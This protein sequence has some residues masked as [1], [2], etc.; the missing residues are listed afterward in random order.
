M[1][2]AWFFSGL[3]NSDEISVTSVTQPPKD[4]RKLRRRTRNR[5]HHSASVCI[6]T[7]SVV[8]PQR[9]VKSLQIAS[10]W[11]KN[12]G[13][14]QIPCT[15]VAHYSSILRL[16]LLLRIPGEENEE[17]SERVIIFLFQYPV[18]CVLYYFELW[19]TNAHNY[20]TNYHTPTC[21]D[22][23]VSSSDSL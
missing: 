10:S 9:N 1:I 20:F 17:K 12:T 15:K 19:P 14:N 2:Y 5:K 22:T 23:I 4:Q 3:P 6:V 7:A 21:F 11:P 8:I 13:E 16:S 18:P